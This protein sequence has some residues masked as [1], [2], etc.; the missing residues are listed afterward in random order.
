MK[1][2]VSGYFAPLH[3]GHIEYFKKAKRLGYL[4]VILNNDKQLFDKRGVKYPVEDRKAI[5]SELRDVDEVFVSIDTDQSVCK[6]L[7]AIIN[8]YKKSNCK[9]CH[10][11]KTNNEN[12]FCL[13]FAK[14]GD[15]LIGEI[16]EA[17]ICKKLG[18][19]VVDGLGKK[20]QS[21]SKLLIQNK[22]MPYYKVLRNEVFGEGWKAGEIIEMDTHAAKIRVE[23]EDLEYLGESRPEK[24]KEKNLKKK[25]MPKGKKLLSLHNHERKKT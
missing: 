5:I 17:K 4:I 21:S 3:R 14:G 20:I 23:N 16:P 24:P 22:N 9:N 12:E 7:E 1:I 8:K 10:K 11:E 6:S 18:I 15:R 19:K 13:I 25:L 2:V